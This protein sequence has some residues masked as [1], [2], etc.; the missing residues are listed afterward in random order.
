MDIRPKRTVRLSCFDAWR[1]PSSRMEGPRSIVSDATIAAISSAMVS[2][3][4]RPPK[5][6]AQCCRRRARN[7]TG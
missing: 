5:R 1:S 4:A 6:T 3:I 2:V 7:F